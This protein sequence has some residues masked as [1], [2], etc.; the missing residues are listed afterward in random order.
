MIVIGH[1]DN[2][3]DKKVIFFMGFPEC[4]K[5]NPGD[6]PLVEP[7]R[8]VISSADQMVGVHCLYNTQGTSHA[9]GLA[10][11]L[12]KCSDTEVICIGIA[13]VL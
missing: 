1:K 4:L 13:K 3:M 10:R 6:L 12:P 2:M 11:A 9:L 8:P 7:E 5:D